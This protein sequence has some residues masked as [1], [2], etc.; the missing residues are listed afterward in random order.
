VITN[1]DNLKSQENNCSEVLPECIFEEKKFP[2]QYLTRE[3][4]F[5]KDIANAAYSNRTELAGRIMELYRDKDG[6]IRVLMANQRIIIPD[7]DQEQDLDYYKCYFQQLLYPAIMQCPDSDSL[8]TPCWYIS[9]GESYEE[10]TTKYP[11]EIEVECIKAAN[12][13]EWSK[14]AN[15]LVPKTI[16]SGTVIVLPVCK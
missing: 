6:G 13:T 10:L 2:C 5:A 16:E 7:P 3:N 4:E 12:K 11:I 14:E 9:K 8:T 1:Q 15:N